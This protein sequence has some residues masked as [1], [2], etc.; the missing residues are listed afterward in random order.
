VDSNSAEQGEQLGDGNACICNDPPKCSLPQ[1][2]MIGHDNASKWR[3]TTQ[4]H[5][6]TALASEHEPRAFQGSAQ[7]TAG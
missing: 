1:N 6:A 2:T 4:D 7:L 3:V 5:V